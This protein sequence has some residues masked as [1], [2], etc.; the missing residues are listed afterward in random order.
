MRI[1]D[2]VIGSPTKACLYLE[3]ESRLTEYDLVAERRVECLTT[4]N[5]VQEVEMIRN[6]SEIAR[7]ATPLQPSWGERSHATQRVIDAIMNSA[8]QDGTNVI[9]PD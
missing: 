6:F 2:F 3:T 8:S 5:C 4:E 9:I 7:G 1:P